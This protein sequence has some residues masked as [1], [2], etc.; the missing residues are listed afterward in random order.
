[1]NLRELRILALLP[2]LA[3]A[4]VASADD[5]NSITVTPSIRYISIGGDAQ[6][7][8]QFNLMKEHFTGGIEDFTLDQ[9]TGKDIEVHAEGHVLFGEQD[10]KLQLEITKPQA[11][12]FRTHFSQYRKYYDNTGGVYSYT[13]FPSLSFSLGRDLYLDIGNFSVDFGL[14]LP[15]LPQI[16]LGYERQFKDGTKSLTGWSG[17]TGG[18][19]SRKIYP[20]FKGIDEVVDIV[21]LSVEHD[22]NIFHVADDLRYENYRNKTARAESGTVTLPVLTPASVSTYYENFSHD[23]FVNTFRVESQ[24]NEKIYCSLGYLFTTLTGGDSLRVQTLPAAAGSRQYYSNLIALDQR[25][26]VLNG[27]AMFGPFNGLTINCGIQAESTSNKAR[28]DVN[29]QTQGGAAVP[30]I[31]N[32]SSEEGMIEENFGLRYTKIPFTTLYLDTRCRQGTIDEG[33]IQAVNSAFQRQYETVV[34]SEDIRIGFNTSP[35][36]R[37]TLSGYYR[38]NNSDYEYQNNTDPSQRANIGEQKFATHELS[39]KLTVRP[40]S[41]LNLSLKYQ[42]VSTAIDTTSMRSPTGV[43]NGQTTSDSGQ[44]D[45]HIYTL[46]ATYTPMDRLYLTGLVSYQTAC[47]FSRDYSNP[48][49]QPFVGDVY[50]VMGSFGYAIDKKTDL[51]GDYSVSWAKNNQANAAIALP[52]GANY[53]QHAATLTLSRQITPK[54]RAQLRYGFYQYNDLAVAGLN[55]YTAHL[56]MA[57]CAIRF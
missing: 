24:V 37:M 29:L 5:T 10:Y 57:S 45:S 53:T 12:F 46:S 21:K 14:T 11:W 40:F 41:R 23:A 36:N 51:T 1:M 20:T 43:Y 33:E 35:I 38:Y 18:A 32:T 54:I 26:H 52:L 31:S 48:I 7:F 8:R 2:L 3:I 15:N 25:G 22:I 17:V 39:T 13:G 19:T 34:N 47:T 16:T 4:A 44:Y 55:D 50:S 9:R 42:L 49:V 27:S 30:V 56:I 6:K 28:N